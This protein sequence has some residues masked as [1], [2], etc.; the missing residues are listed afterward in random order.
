MNKVFISLLTFND[1]KST[2]E[3]LTSLN[4]LNKDGIDLNVL[5]IDNAS[6]N[7]FTSDKDYENFN[8]KIIRNDKNLGF[9][10]GH[11]IGI[12]YA[13][14][15]GANYITILNNDTEVDENLITASIKSFELNTGI[16]VPK[17][18]F[19]KGYEY[20]KER[21][22]END[23]GKVIWYAGG[24]IDWGNVIGEH[25]GV[26]EI[27]KGD[28]TKRFETEIAT[29]CCMMVKSEVFKTVGYLSEK[30]FLYYEDAD[31]S[32][33]VHKNGYRIIFEP[34][35]IV[36]HKNAASTG[37]SGSQLQD[38]YITRNRL[39]FGFKYASPRVKAALFRE[40]LRLIRHGRPWQKVAIKDF[41]KGRMGKGSYKND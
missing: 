9:S 24:R 27:D 13:L 8:L 20:H 23:K 30:Y 12:K 40:S 6:D 2:T 32:I 19:A 21:Y 11:N 1:N 18:Y 17:I 16:V 29:G 3:C 5:V 25:L 10:G 4:K 14:E 37:G 26:D 36:W 39:F 7:P 38:Y 34:K 33:R 28:F 31:F 15:N 35:A 22:S 41:F